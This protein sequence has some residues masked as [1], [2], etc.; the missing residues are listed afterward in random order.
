VRA[1]R[2]DALE[3]RVG[4]EVGDLAVDDDPGLLADL[5]ELH[6]ARVLLGEVFR[7][8][9]GCLVH[10]LVGV[11]DRRLGKAHHHSVTIVAAAVPG[12]P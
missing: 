1:R 8:Q 11:E 4:D 10:M 3:R 2:R 6:G 7:Q 12:A 5:G 9:R